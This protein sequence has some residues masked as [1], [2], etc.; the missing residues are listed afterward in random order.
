[1][2]SC[3]QF[4]A[5]KW[6]VIHPFPNVYNFTPADELVKFAKKVNAKFHG[7]NFVWHVTLTLLKSPTC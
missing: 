3:L 1:M 5:V 4:G 7:H 6:E 2:K